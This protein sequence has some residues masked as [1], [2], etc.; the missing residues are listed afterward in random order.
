[1]CINKATTLG[2]VTRVVRDE[3]ANIIIGDELRIEVGTKI[4][5]FCGYNT[6]EKILKR[7]TIAKILH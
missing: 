6:F 5:Y 7:V 2:R 3:I 4:E 1:M